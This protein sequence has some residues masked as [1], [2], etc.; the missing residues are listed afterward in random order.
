MPERTWKPIAIVLG[1]SA[2]IASGT[3]PVSAHARRA[4][5]AV[6]PL[7]NIDFTVVDGRGRVPG[8]GEAPVYEA[9]QRR[10]VL[11]PDRRPVTY[12]EFL[13][14]SGD[15]TVRC[16]SPGT[17]LR[18]RLQGLI[19][20]GSYSLWSFVFDAPGWTP[21]LEWARAAGALGSSGVQSFVASAGGEAFVAITVPRGPLSGFGI[22]RGCGLDEFEWKIVGGYNLDG[23]PPSPLAPPADRIVEQFGFTVKAER[24]RPRR[25][26]A[27]PKDG[28]ASAR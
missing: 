23:V 25:A 6:V 26:A 21:S 1:L 11:S 9:R 12:A 15:L 24:Y 7:D 13:R 19:P 4:R 20:N 5:E 16:E 10:P 22:M 8:N 27:A 14:P 18:L 28:G 2:A 3:I 17:T